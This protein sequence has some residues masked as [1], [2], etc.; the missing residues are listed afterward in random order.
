VT[1]EK[2]KL[3]FTYFTNDTAGPMVVEVRGL[4]VEG[5]LLTGTFVLNKK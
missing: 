4:T 5:D 3:S 1:D 2:G